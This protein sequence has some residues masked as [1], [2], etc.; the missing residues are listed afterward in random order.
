MEQRD[1]VKY[2]CYDKYCRLC[3]F[4]A[5]AFGYNPFGVIEN[6]H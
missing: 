3:Y 5:T 1:Y 4:K 2:K 6:C